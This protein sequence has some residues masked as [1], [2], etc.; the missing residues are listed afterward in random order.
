MANKV[1]STENGKNKLDQKNISP[2]MHLQTLQDLDI[3]C[4]G[5]ARLSI[6]SGVST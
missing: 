6:D 1:I 5:V 2:C 4:V 3:R